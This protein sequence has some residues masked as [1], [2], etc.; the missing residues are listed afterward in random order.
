VD[1]KA[2][3]EKGAG[4]RQR[5]KDKYHRQ[6]I[7]SFTDAEIVELLLVLG[8]PRKD[9]KEQ[10][11]ALLA[12]FGS[13]PG[14][15]EAP[16]KELQ[17]VKGIGP[18]NSFAVHFLHGVARRYLRQRLPEK[19]YLHSSREV[20]DYLVH[21]MRDLQQEVFAVIFLDAAHAIID[22]QI[23]SRGTITASTVYPR[24]VVK[25]ALQ[26]NAAALVVAHNHPSGAPEPSEQ[27]KQLT[28]TLFLACGLMNIRLLD[29][30]IVGRAAE[31]FS[32]ADHGIMKSISEAC[33][34]LLNRP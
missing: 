12:R 19:Q 17:K 25:L 22:S 26:H 3:Q 5:L 27:D 28:R 24:E 1:K 8:T 32:F 23:V 4:H 2:W 20:S 13:L 7:E 34:R 6:G 11:R 31:T 21:S 9:C 14:V 33:S 16:A 18:N 30:I 15:L 29:H 10:A